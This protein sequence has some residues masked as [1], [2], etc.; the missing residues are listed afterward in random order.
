MILSKEKQSRIVFG[1]SLTS[2]EFNTKTLVQ[3]FQIAFHFHP[4]HRKPKTYTFQSYEY[5][6]IVYENCGVKTYMKEDHHSRL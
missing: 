6:K 5:M 2:R 1:R 4:G 3:F